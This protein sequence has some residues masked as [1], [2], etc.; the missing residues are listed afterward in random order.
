MIGE[1][2][3]A[4]HK[5]MFKVIPSC[6]EAMELQSRAVDGELGVGK[7]ML[8]AIHV[9]M[10]RVCRRYGKQVSH[11]SEFASEL[12]ERAPM[13]ELHPMPPEVKERIRKSIHSR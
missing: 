9:M 2:K 10:C 11:V 4:M 1:M 12:P 3:K 8:V 7:R 13:G 5:V 6:K